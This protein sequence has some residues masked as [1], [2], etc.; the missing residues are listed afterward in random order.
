[1]LVNGLYNKIDKYWSFYFLPHPLY[2]SMREKMLLVAI[3]EKKKL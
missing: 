2:G 3:I 1:M